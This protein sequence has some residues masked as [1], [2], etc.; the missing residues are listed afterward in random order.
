MDTRTTNNKKDTDAQKITNIEPIFIPGNQTTNK[1]MMIILDNTM[2]D[3]EFVENNAMIGHGNALKD[4]LSNTN[5]W[6]E[7]AISVQSVIFKNETMD[8]VCFFPRNADTKEIVS[9]FTEAFCEEY[10]VLQDGKCSVLTN[11]ALD[12]RNLLKVNQAMYPLA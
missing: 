9:L 5:E 4:F 6:F 11:F 12:K 2:F 3:Y 1:N 10:R 7:N 8:R